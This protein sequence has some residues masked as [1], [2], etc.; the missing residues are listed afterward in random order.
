MELTQFPFQT[1]NSFDSDPTIEY[2]RNNFVRVVKAFLSQGKG[3]GGTELDVI[4]K[5]LDVMH[6]FRTERLRNVLNRIKILN[7][8]HDL[9]DT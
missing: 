8:D 7:R 5:A 6:Y 9:I 3:E 2:N 1:R 4:Q